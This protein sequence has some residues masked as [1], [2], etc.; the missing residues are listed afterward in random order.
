MQ[1]EVDRARRPSLYFAAKPPQRSFNSHMPTP[2]HHNHFAWGL[3]LAFALAAPSLLAF[4]VPP[5]ATLLNQL[6]A[7]AG[8]GGVTWVAAEA[9]QVRWAGLRKQLP[10]PGVV[11]LLLLALL[12]AASL[13]LPLSLALQTGV[14]LVLALLLLGVSWA[15][16]LPDGQGGDASVTA[17]A[18]AMLLAGLLSAAVAMVQVFAPAWTSWG[19]G[20]VIARSGLPGRAVG[21]LRQPNHLS[22]LLLW[23]LIAWV[24]LANAGRWFSRRLP[25]AIWAG[26]GVVLVL[27]VVLTASRTGSVGILLIAA[28]GVVDKRLSRRVRLAMLAAPLVY[29]LCWALMASWAHSTA[30]TF[31]GEV[32]LSEGDLSASRFGI[33]ANTLALIR[34]NPWAGVGLG[35]F[36][37]A[38][39]LSPFPGRPVAFFDHTHNLP[40][41]LAVELGLPMAA[42]IMALLLWALGQAAGRAWR[43]Q[44]DDGAA[45]RAAFMMVLMI[46]VHSLLEYPLWYAY[47]LLPTAWAWGIALREPDAASQ[48]PAAPASPWWLAVGLGMVLGSAWALYDYSKVTAIFSAGDGSLSLPERIARGRSSVLFGHHADYANVT[49]SEPPSQAMS[50]FRTTTHSLL[51]TRLMIA[52]ARALDET[53]ERDKARYLA[54]RLREFHNPDAK[55]FFAACDEPAQASGEQPFQC[56]PSQLPHTWREFSN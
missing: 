21:N 15:S 32:R 17:F 10:L 12:Y 34:A 51:D 14:L 52:W 24:P 41:Q 5:S 39:T 18:S 56:E 37:L 8:W 43:V 1:G 22:S 26:L 45:S 31:G 13:G 7:V 20:H 2:S 16:R 44:G 4:N 6:L 55:E 49:V 40:L 35:E 29:L 38:W 54:E 23:A 30:N 25:V 46:G 36:N 53:G 50:S 42:A 3:A 19:D 48:P 9:G 28:W 33:W 27:A 11:L 47:F